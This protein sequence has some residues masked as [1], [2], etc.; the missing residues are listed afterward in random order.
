M[1]NIEEI[2]EKE[3]TKHV[4]SKEGKKGNGRRGLGVDPMKK[5]RREMGSSDMEKNSN[6]PT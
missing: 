5:K 2:L 4:I 1:L 3:V 6:N